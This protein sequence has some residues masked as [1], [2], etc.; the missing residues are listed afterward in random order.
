MKL[1]I[2]TA[3][4]VVILI[5]SAVKAT[6]I[7]GGLITS[8]THWTADAG[9]YI[10][11][12]SIIVDNS[13][14]LLI[15]PGTEV[16]FH[17]AKALIVSSG[18]LIARGT[19]AQ[20]ICFTS[21][22]GWLWGY[23]GL[24]PGAV[25]ASYA[26]GQYAGG[27]IIENAIIENA[28]YGDTKAAIQVNTTSPLLS[29]NVIRSNDCGGIY[30]WEA[31]RTHITG[32]H[33]EGN[34]SAFG[35]GIYISETDDIKI[36]NNIITGNRA[37]QDG[38]GIYMNCVTAADLSH[39][40]ISLNSN[41]GV[42]IQNTDSLFVTSDRMLNN[43][44]YAVK[45]NSS[46]SDIVLSADP[47]DPT[48]I[49][50]DHYD[51]WDRIIHNVDY[52]LYYDSRSP[53]NVDARHVWWGTTN[54]EFINGYI[55][56]FQDDPSKGIV[57]HD[58]YIIWA[59]GDA[60]GDH[61]IDGSDFQL[62]NSHKFGPGR[63]EEGDFNGDWAVDGSDFQIWNSNKFTSYDLSSAPAAT[64]VP[65][66]ATLSLLAFSAVLIVSKN[67]LALSKRRS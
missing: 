3:F 27:S 4:A 6:T 14:I 46:C 18:Q 48:W 49:V 63:W 7:V 22:T 9:P 35:G 21:A 15:D 25:G 26:N 38:G 34:E 56:D 29:N 58:P 20:Q 43:G 39:N 36:S 54:L 44:G 65:E 57:F 2:I 19:D 17:E 12:E 52:Q 64:E 31:H 51:Y 10:V 62:W 5:N 42:F 8:D 11:T 13:A 61:A 50:Y 59:Y 45:T 67:A 66:P 37:Y 40:T 41:G 30:L 16:K 60:N 23:I 53:G 55:T 24:G 1:N 28:G 32:N 33:I 47:N